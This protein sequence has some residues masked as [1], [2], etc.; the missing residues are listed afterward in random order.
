MFPTDICQT[1]FLT[2]RLRP[3]CTDVSSVIYQPVAEITA[4]FRRDDL[5]KFHL[6]FLRFLDSVKPEVSLNIKKQ[7]PVTLKSWK[8]F[9][10]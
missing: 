2:M 1:A 8:I 9:R 3:R 7:L 6:Y 10:G 5:P 4:F